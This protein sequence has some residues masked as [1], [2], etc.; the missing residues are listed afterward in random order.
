ARLAPPGGATALPA[1][2]LVAGATGT[3]DEALRASPGFSLFRR[4]SS[5]ASNPT[6]QGVTLRGLSSS[7][8]GRT[9]VLVDGAP[10]NDPF[11][12]WVAW[13]KLPI[14]AIECVEVVRG[15]AGDLYG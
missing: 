15:A 5:A 3:V 2:D 14:A 9:L 6:T 4:T 10:L 11:G 13:D 7:G 1:R 12:S 8:A